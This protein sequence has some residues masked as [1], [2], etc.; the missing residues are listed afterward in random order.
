MYYPDVIRL[1]KQEEHVR[2][3]ITSYDRL[4][5]A[6]ELSKIYETAC[7]RYESIGC[8]TRPCGCPTDRDKFTQEIEDAA[9]AILA[10]ADGRTMPKDGS[11]D[12]V[13]TNV[14]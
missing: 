13:S 7:E 6:I 8:T 14:T 11:A 2:K 9:R 1:T 3:C 4:E 5:S 12:G 10:A